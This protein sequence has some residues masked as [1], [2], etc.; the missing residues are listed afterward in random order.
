M[1][2][3]ASLLAVS[4][5]LLIVA[6]TWHSPQ[7]MY[8]DPA[9]QFKALQQHLAGQSP[10]FNTLVQPDAADLSRNRYQW[11]S[12]W[13][14]LMGL[15]V[16]GLAKCGTGILMA[17]R[18]L[19]IAGFVTGAAGW[20]VWAARF[21]L[22]DWLLYS[23]AAGM[24]FIRYGNNALFTYSAEGLAFALGPWL[25]VLSVQLASRWSVSLALTAG[26]VLGAAYWAKYSLAIASLGALLFLFWRVRWKSLWTAVP[27]ISLI[28]A[29]NL[30]NRV[31]GGIS[32]L[33]T[34]NPLR[35]DLNWRGVISPF[36]FVPLAMADLDSLL[37]YL[38]LSPGHP[39]AQA[40]VVIYAIALP[41]TLLL[42]FLLR[43]KRSEEWLGVTL[44]I[45]SMISLGA[46]WLTA[47]SVS[48]EARHL[49]TA[50]LGLIPVAAASAYRRWPAMSRTGRLTITIAA[51]VYLAVPVAYGA[52]SVIGKRTRILPPAIGALPHADVL[53]LPNPVA[54]L[55]VDGREIITWADFEPE[56][57][58]KGQAYRTSVPMHVA[59]LLP[60]HFEQNGKADI[61]RSSFSQARGWTFEG[62]S[63]T[64]HVWVAELKP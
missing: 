64:Y 33:V 2:L 11:I 21:E 19:A 43:P 58:L 17:I 48:F 7:L 18:I 20:A 22:P 40:E 61:I 8:S 51:V 36:A 47:R 46:L 32:S 6:L 15:I 29:L 3:R 9:W 27:C 63:G 49:A 50:A 1:L 39:L 42:L 62:T 54:A 13:P 60:P 53:Y 4:S 52:A 59:L 41:G 26:I 56:W 31:M 16:W 57:M 55:Q 45:V 14:I 25:L 28:L 10:T 23:I 12:H 24:P 37:H 5:A 38:L 35:V 34:E 30:L 44:A